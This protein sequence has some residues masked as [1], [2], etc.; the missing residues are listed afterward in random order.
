MVEL[1]K[2]YGDESS[3]T[4]INWI[5]RKVFKW[6]VG[7]AETTKTRIDP[8]DPQTTKDAMASLDL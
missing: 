5:G 6:L 1:A 3:P 8:N 2:R 4:L 7:D